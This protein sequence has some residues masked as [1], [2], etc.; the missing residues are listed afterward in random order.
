MCHLLCAAVYMQAAYVQR[1]LF[2][3]MIRTL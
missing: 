3:R 2:D 1:L